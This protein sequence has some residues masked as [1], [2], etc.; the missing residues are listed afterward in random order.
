MQ[1]IVIPLLLLLALLT[2]GCAGARAI[3]FEPWSSPSQVKTDDD[4]LFDI[5]GLTV[6][7]RSRWA[8]QPPITSRLDPMGVPSCVTIH[9]EGQ[10]CSMLC[11]SDV[12]YR[13]RCIRAHQIK[14]PQQGGL[15]AG[16]VGYHFLIDREGR[17]WEGRQLKYQGAHAG[18]S[19]ANRHNI[20]ICLLGNM[21]LQHPSVAQ[22]ESLRRLVVALMDKY[23]VNSACVYTHREVKERF[24]LPPTECPGRNLQAYVDI[25]RSRFRVANR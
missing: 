22:K 13:L 18:N 17:T 8:E 6:L 1:K 20:G 21:N 5:S 2:S 7:R 19:L 9:H 15:G 10:P 24:G 16:D 4:A 12:A 14:S 25:L 11:A 23:D 3:S